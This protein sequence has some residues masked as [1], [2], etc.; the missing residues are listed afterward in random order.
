MRLKK[1]ASVNKQINVGRGMARKTKA[2]GTDASNSAE[3]PQGKNSTS[4]TQKHRAELKARE[5]PRWEIPTTEET[6][7]I[8]RKIAKSEGLNISVAAE[9]LLKL[10]IETYLSTHTASDTGEY[11]VVKPT[12]ISDTL[13]S[14]NQN[15]STSTPASVVICNPSNLN[16]PHPSKIKPLIKYSSRTTIRPLSEPAQHKSLRDVANPPADDD[17]CTLG[18]PIAE[19][20][21]LLFRNKER[22]A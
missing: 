17:A 10:G 20:Q 15:S 14:I 22:K 3:V 9:A 12:L 13:L 21:K 16:Q 8:V 19:Y 1:Y 18:I 7:T 2:S 4:R 5:L 11:E 6:R